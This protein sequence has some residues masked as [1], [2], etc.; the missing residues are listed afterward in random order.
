MNLGRKEKVI[1][2][3]VSV[4]CISIVMLM[5]FI[6]INLGDFDMETPGNTINTSSDATSSIMPNST[7]SENPTE[8]SAITESV[9]KTLEQSPTTGDSIIVPQTDGPVFFGVASSISVDCIDSNFVKNEIV[10]KLYYMGIPE[11]DYT[12]KSPNN[13]VEI[14]IGIKSE[15]NGFENLYVN[16][17]NIIYAGNVSQH[18]ENGVSVDKNGEEIEGDMSYLTINLY[19]K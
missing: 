13:Y 4:L 14:R 16:M 17:L 8:T 7:Q 19:N 10:D 2:G 6:C 9:D 11:S 3:V 1:I 18:L 12:I 5:V 15:E